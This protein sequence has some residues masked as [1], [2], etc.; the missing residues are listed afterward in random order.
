ME[1]IAMAEAI[2]RENIKHF[3]K[4]LKS[5]VHEAKRKT[6]LTLLSGEEGKLAE[7]IQRKKKR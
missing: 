5:E 2:A 7:A 1:G 6:L 4:L 3:R